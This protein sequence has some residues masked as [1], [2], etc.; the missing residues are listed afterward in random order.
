MITIWYDYI[1]VPN[2][3]NS[4]VVAAGIPPL[5]CDLSFSAV[6]SSPGVTSSLWVLE[7]W[8]GALA[9]TKDGGF[10]MAAPVWSSER[11]FPEKCRQRE[12]TV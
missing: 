8:V 11:L 9:A 3:K 4:P 2:I 5:T 7:S 12:E 6:T 1:I 10:K